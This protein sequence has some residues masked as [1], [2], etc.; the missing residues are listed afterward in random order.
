MNILLLGG[1]GFLGKGLQEVMKAQNDTVKSVDI[2][3][4]DL[5]DSANIDKIVEDLKD[6]QRVVILAAK[7]GVKLFETD[8]INAAN[9]NHRVFDNIFEAIKIASKKYYHKFSV[10][11]YSTSEVYGSLKYPACIITPMTPVRTEF[12][13]IRSNYSKEKLEDEEKL[14]TAYKDGLLSS[15]TIIRPFNISGKNQKIG[16][17]YSMVKDALTKNTISYNRN[18]TRTITGIDEASMCCYLHIKYCPTNVYN[19][20]NDKCSLYMK[21][22]AEIVAEVLE[23]NVGFIELPEDTEIQYRHVSSPDQF[24]GLA[25]N[26]LRPHIL[27]LKEEI[28]NEHV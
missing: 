3:D 7:L 10:I 8:G 19:I 6:I 16:V 2:N 4:Y 9:H 22:L 27:Q 24:V 12:N 13:T 21:T 28:L 1:N 20:A 11:Y 17:L 26:I 25:K 18:T 5:S 23:L 15:C 14:M